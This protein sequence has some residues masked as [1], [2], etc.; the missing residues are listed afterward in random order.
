MADTEPQQ[1]NRFPR[2]VFPS[3]IPHH[4]HVNLNGHALQNPGVLPAVHT[5]AGNLQFDAHFED[6]PQLVGHVAQGRP[7]DHQNVVGVVDY[8]RDPA[9]QHANVGHA[10]GIHAQAQPNAVEN[11]E[12]VLFGHVHPVVPVPVQAAFHDPFGRGIPAPVQPAAENLRRLAGRY[13]YHHDSQVDLV[14]MEPG[15]AGRC[16]LLIVL[17]VADLL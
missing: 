8:H 11:Q 13:L 14:S 3:P 2:D 17:D 10:H 4:W 9:I 16:K 15:A 7:R 6:I 5:Q 12:H 1:V